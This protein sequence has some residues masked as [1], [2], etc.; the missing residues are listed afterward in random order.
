VAAGAHAAGRRRAAGG[1]AERR[2]RELTV[3]LYE[4][5]MILVLIG[6]VL[7]TV[8][9]GA[10]FG[11]GL[12]QLLAGPGPRGHQIR[13]H[14]HAAMG[15]VWE[16]NHVWLIFV[17]TVT[18]T[19]YPGAFGAIMTTLAVPVFIAAV[20]II[21]RGASYAL[22]SGT[23]NAEQSR[24]IDLVF[25]LSSLLTPFA[26]GTIVGAI[27]SGRVPAGELAV[28]PFSSWLNP[29]SILIGAL[30]VL[31]SAYLAAVFMAADAQRL[32][33]HGLVEQMR[34]R[35][36][37]SGALAGAVAIAGFAVLHSDAHRLFEHLLRGAALAG[38]IVSVLAG[39]TALGL[40]RTRRFEAAR[41]VAA[42]AV[43]AVI[44]GWALAQYP[45]LL[46][47][48]TVAQAAAPRATLVAVVVSVAV[49]AVLL[50]PS[51][52]LLFG[53]L[54]GG[55]LDEGADRQSTAAARLSDVPQASAGGFQLRLAVALVIAG[56]GLLTVAEAPWAHLIGVLALLGFVL[57]GFL[58]V[59]PSELAEA[60][61]QQAAAPA[62]RPGSGRAP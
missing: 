52:A 12:W 21:L 10:D 8:L 51:L 35:A 4:L 49:G 19:A 58:A 20:G 17:L 37:C 42:L 38:P 26:L 25:A 13:D 5:P 61:E 14:A 59:A 18:W 62:R 30:A 46:P 28:H 11:A 3:H 34:V 43:A 27:A 22:R 54:L 36:L 9:A 55:Q 47:G 7:Y 2:E 29:T 48:L 53:L 56:F 60:G 57:V 32:G 16:A 15:P 45:T 39:L 50:F 31:S 1:G 41:Y 40:V 44:G 33:E 23:T 24:P 6:L